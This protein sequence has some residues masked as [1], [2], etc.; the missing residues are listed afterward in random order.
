MML[1]PPPSLKK[2]TS[3]VKL[4]HAHILKL[5]FY[6]KH[7]QRK[8]TKIDL[9]FG[10]EIWKVG[11]A[12]AVVVGNNDDQWWW[13]WRWW[14]WCWWVLFLEFRIWCVVFFRVK[15]LKTNKKRNS[16]YDQNIWSGYQEYLLQ[17]QLEFLLNLWWEK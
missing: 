9:G 5:H 1:S 2:A 13:Q 6:L 4:R 3:M 15:W 17:C 8:E 7:Q 11:A 14:R 12:M 10:V 16:S